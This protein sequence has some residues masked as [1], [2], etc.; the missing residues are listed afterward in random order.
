MTF[1]AAIAAEVAAATAAAPPSG[2]N[3]SAR[4][5]TT[6]VK[7]GVIYVRMPETTDTIITGRCTM[8]CPLCRKQDGG[9]EAMTTE[10]PDVDPDPDPANMT[11]SERPDRDEKVICD[12]CGTEY[13]AVRGEC[14]TCH[15]PPPEPPR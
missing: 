13:A 8:G 1:P 11:T 12:K 14:P 6:L 15:P 10:R 5:T 9:V 2:P 7:N 4:T 3:L